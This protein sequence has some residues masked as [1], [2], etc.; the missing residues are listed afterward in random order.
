MFNVLILS[1]VEGVKTMNT[2]L[3]EFRK[4]KRMSQQELASV[5]GVSRKTISDLE[6][7]IERVYKTD[8]L[9]KLSSA[10]SIGVKTLFFGK[11]V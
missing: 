7:N 1:Y 5:S 4:K 10:L 6:N 9:E 3:R 2:R 8:T 11:N